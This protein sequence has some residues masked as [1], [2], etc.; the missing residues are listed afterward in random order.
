MDFDRWNV[1]A[2][3]HEWGILLHH[4]IG[5]AATVGLLRATLSQ[6]PELFQVTL[7]KIVYSGVHCG[8]Y[9]SADRV[10]ALL[11]ELRSLH[12]V[13]LDNT[14]DERLVRYFESQLRELVEAA[15]QV[16]KPISF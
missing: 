2:C 16:S 14:R 1:R 13:H 10:P 15:L 4:W 5:N 11:P 3:E 9:I 8:D 12:E 7:S 6:H